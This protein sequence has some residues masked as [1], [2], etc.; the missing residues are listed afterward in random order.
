VNTYGVSADLSGTQAAI[1]DSQGNSITAQL[2]GAGGSLGALLQEKNVT[3]PG[4][5]SQ[6]DNIAQVFADTVNAALAQGLDVN[7][8]PPVTSLFTYS[9][10]NGVA[11]TIAVTGITPG[12]IAAASVGAPGGNSNA[13]AVAQLAGAPAVNGAT[14][15]QAY[16]DLGSRVGHDV[17]SAR[18]DRQA[19]QDLVTQ[20]QQQRA[21]ASGVSLDAEA[22]K[23]M[24]FQ[25]N[26][27]AVGK[28]VTVL[29]DLTQTVIN[30]IR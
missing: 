28:L 23:L 29:D 16:G 14:F 13:I 6:L 30:L 20:V 17:S 4:Y 9:A 21:L 1:L 24:Q 27:Q 12:E 5:L 3:L 22:V 18:Q 10:A 2:Q 15:V 19:Q 26:Y 7:G 8:N 25:Q 11:A